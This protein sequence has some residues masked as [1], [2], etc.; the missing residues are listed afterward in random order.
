MPLLV[1]LSRL[2]TVLAVIGLVM[3]AA[4]APSAASTERMPAMTMSGDMPDCEGKPT[5]CDDMKSCPFMVV[6]VAKLA[7][8]LPTVVAI[9]APLSVPVRIGLRNDAEGPTRAT[10]PLPRP[11]EA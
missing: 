1:A 6:C 2:L 7:Q 8:V 4:T 10:P 3:G 5:D 11:P 9:K